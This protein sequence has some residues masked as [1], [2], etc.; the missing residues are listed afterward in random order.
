MT[1]V[2]GV[3]A[4]VPAPGDQVSESSRSEAGSQGLDAV[5]APRE[6]P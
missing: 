5:A 1:R 6:L 2:S 4:L 3:P